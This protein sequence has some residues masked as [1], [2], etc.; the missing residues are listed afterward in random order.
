MT[1]K[2]P[3]QPKPFYDSVVRVWY[4]EVAQALLSL[5]GPCLKNQSSSFR[6]GYMSCLFRNQP[7][8]CIFCFIMQQVER[9]EGE[10]FSQ[11]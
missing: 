4:G 6:F 3:F 10:L 7:G 11:P 9:K 8:V 5:C 2:G 1:S